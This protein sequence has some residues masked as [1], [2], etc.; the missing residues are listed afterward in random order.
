MNSD[1]K[2]VFST[3]IKGF[4]ATAAKL[5]TRE[6]HSGGKRF[7]LTSKLQVLS[8]PLLFFVNTE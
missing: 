5:F 2:I 7:A 3:Y 6:N 1:T 4:S 8:S